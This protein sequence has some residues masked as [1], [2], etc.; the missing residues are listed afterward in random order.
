MGNLR[1]NYTV[2][3]PVSMRSLFFLFSFFSFSFS[4]LIIVLLIYRIGGEQG[5]QLEKQ[6]V[7]NNDDILDLLIL[8]SSSSSS[9]EFQ[10]ALVTNSNQVRILQQDFSSTPLEGHTD[11]VLAVDCSPNGYCIVLLYFHL[12]RFLF[13]VR[14]LRSCI[15]VL[16]IWYLQSKELQK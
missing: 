9:S 6:I 12:L 14:N 2:D 1:L 4:S 5:L 8:P 16:F 13:Y 15:Y 11:I 10:M 7:G 3:T